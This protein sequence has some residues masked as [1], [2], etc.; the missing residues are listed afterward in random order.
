[1]DSS[2][3]SL[4][5][6]IASSSS[7]SRLTCAP[8]AKWSQSVAS[9]QPCEPNTRPPS[10]RADKTSSKCAAHLSLFMTQRTPVARPQSGDNGRDACARLA[11]SKGCASLAVPRFGRRGRHFSSSAQLVARVSGRVVCVLWQTGAGQR[12]RERERSR[13][14]YLARRVGPK[15]RA[16][17]GLLGGHSNCDLAPKKRAR[18]KWRRKRKK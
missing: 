12:E 18:E 3:A 8:A 2:E 13:S 7:L 17:L 4:R 11:P 16:P 15:W 10:S 5:I 14:I 9:V 1:M 6:A